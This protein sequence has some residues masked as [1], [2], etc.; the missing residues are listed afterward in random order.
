MERMERG[1][2]QVR[3]EQL[4]MVELER[5]ENW[6]E[7]MEGRCRLDQ[8]GD[9]LGLMGNHFQW[10]PTEDCWAR[11]EKRWRLIAKVVLQDRMG[12]R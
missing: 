7:E 3:T 8:M 6:L 12:N 11:M 4:I 2:D 10:I 5:M 1:W 9:Q